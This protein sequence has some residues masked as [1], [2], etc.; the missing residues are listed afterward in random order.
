MIRFG[1]NRCTNLVHFDLLQG[2]RLRPASEGYTGNVR[3]LVIPE[4]EELK[5]RLI[6]TLPT[7]KGK[8]LAETN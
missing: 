3:A 5:E 2:T 4:E 7:K 6:Q 8:R 1:K